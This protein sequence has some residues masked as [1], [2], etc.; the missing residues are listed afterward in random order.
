MDDKDLLRKR[1]KEKLAERID[2]SKESSDEE[3]LELIDDMLIRE[4]KQFPISLAQR[5]QLSKELFHAFRKL[6]VLQELIDDA[7]ITEIMVNGPESIYIERNG[8]LSK[9]GLCFESREKLQYVI[10]QIVAD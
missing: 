2:Y 1:L 10:Q 6:D 3:I 7:Q 8:R 4:T 9:S 5:Q